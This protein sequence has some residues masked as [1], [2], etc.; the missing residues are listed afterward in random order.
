MIL[1]FELGYVLKVG[2]VFYKIGT[3]HLLVFDFI[4]IKFVKKGK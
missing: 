3:S 4:K 2:S 1:N